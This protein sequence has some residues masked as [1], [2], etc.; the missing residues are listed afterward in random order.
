M[1]NN[2][3]KLE[4]LR[5]N[6]YTAEYAERYQSAL[7]YVNKINELKEKK[8]GNKEI[9]FAKGEKYRCISDLE[10]IIGDKLGSICIDCG[11]HSY[12]EL[13]TQNGYEKSNDHGIS[14]RRWATLLAIYGED[15]LQCD[16]WFSS[17]HRDGEG[18]LLHIMTAM[19]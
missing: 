8:R 10:K 15:P 16:H 6:E 2:S 14:M 17:N 7:Q 1:S 19:N 11:L 4:F 9:K 13:T 12:L 18:L 3:Y 5:C